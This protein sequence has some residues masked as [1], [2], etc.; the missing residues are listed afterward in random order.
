MRDVVLRLARK[1]NDP[2]YWTRGRLL[3][4]EVV[5]MVKEARKNYIIDNLELYKNDSSKFWETML[6]VLPKKKTA[7]IEV[8]Y[9]PDKRE[10]VRG[11]CAANLI[12]SYF[13]EIGGK[14]NNSIPDSQEDFW[15][16]F[17]EHEFEWGHVIT[18]F[19]IMYVLDQTSLVKSSGIPSLSTR[20]LIDFFKIKTELLC[21]VFNNCLKSGIH[22]AKWKN[23]VM[24][25]IPK[26][27]IPRN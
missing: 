16:N 8:V 3:Q 4:K 23:N 17:S 18:P 21:N 12:N 9:D 11:E 27:T 20:I 5:T 19:D 26:K 10:L 7:P 14:I 24:I 1:H 22:P 6:L 2:N 25:S 13:S 15:P